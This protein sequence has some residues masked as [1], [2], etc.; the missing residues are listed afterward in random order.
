M[1]PVCLFLV[2]RML[3][4]V[5]VYSSKTESTKSNHKTKFI[6]V[7]G[8]TSLASCICGLFDLISRGRCSLAT[9]GRTSLVA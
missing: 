7:N 9:F 4:K 2:T 8:S 3:W 1:S 5:Y 6:V